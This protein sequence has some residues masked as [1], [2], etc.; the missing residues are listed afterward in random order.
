MK[1]SISDLARQEQAIVGEIRQKID[2]LSADAK[3]FIAQETS[4]AERHFVWVVPAAALLGAG[5]E[6]ILSHL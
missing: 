2:D 1:L 6:W 5:I 4:W 3:A